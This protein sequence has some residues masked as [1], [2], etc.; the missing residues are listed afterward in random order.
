MSSPDD[1]DKHFFGPQERHILETVKLIL[2][3][4]GAAVGLD[5][6]ASYISTLHVPKLLVTLL[7]AAVY[8]VLLCDFVY[9]IMFIV[10]TFCVAVNKLLGTVG[11]SINILDA[12]RHVRAWLGPSPRSISFIL[13]ALAVIIAV[14]VIVW[15]GYIPIYCVIESLFFDR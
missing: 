1:D 15:E 3:T 5:Y 4:A 2:L 7:Y 8:I 12:F 11:L 10:V 13:V 14:G 9:L 6:F